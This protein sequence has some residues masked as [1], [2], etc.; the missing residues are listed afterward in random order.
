MFA[1]IRN[2]NRAIYSIIKIPLGGGGG[3]SFNFFQ[4]GAGLGCANPALGTYFCPRGL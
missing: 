1:L 3:G 4:Q 2:K